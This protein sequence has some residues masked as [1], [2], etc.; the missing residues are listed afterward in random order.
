MS[1]ARIEHANITVHDPLATANILIDLF[2]CGTCQ[3]HMDSYLKVNVHLL[4]NQQRVASE[5]SPYRQH[6]PQ[7]AL[8]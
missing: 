6:R 4:G 5:S 3:P 7:A 1:T 2:G 8:Y